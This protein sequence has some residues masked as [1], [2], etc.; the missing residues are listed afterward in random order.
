[1]K[2]LLVFPPQWTPFR[3]Y[4]SLPSL[5]A[6]L[7]EKGITVVQKDFNLEAYDLMLTRPYLSKIS[8]R[9]NTQFAA[10]ELK[11][12]LMPGIEQK[13][14]SDLFMAKSI[15]P[16]L[17]DKV[18]SAKS[19]YRDKDNFFDPDKL[20]SATNIINQALVAI[21]LA[22]FPTIIGLSTFEMSS[23]IG[24][25]ESLKAATQNRIENPY[26]EIFEEHLLPFIKNEQPD[27]IGITISGESQVIPAFTLCSVLR[28]KGIRGHI[29]V[30]GYVI[31]MLADVIPKYPELFERFIDSAIINDG[32]KPL[33]EL[34]KH[35]EQ[36]RSLDTVP[37]LIFRD[38]N[39]IRVNSKEAPE[40]I[41]SLP[42]PSFEGLPLD[43][44]FSPSPVLPL[45][46][47]RGCYWA[48][49][50]FCTHS[51]AY[52]LTYQLRDHVKVVDDIEA[53]SAKY[54]TTHIAFSDEGTS[55]ASVGKIS[56]EILRRGIKI[57]LST[58][59]RPE[60][61][62]TKELAQKMSAAGFKEVY[63]GVES[64]CD[65]VLKQINKGTE[66][67]S[68]EEYCAISMTPAFGITFT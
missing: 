28:Q 52:G 20:E 36:G 11:D 56:D 53:L 50:A 51:L 44:Y 21:S 42:A 32:E 9:L 63:I 26:I 8:E 41:N 57:R 17:A 43:K 25:Y 18:E 2:V 1:M 27:V 47:S 49:C 23:F 24:S 35:L 61:Q 66:I 6:Y 33:T 40:Y 39:K 34:I 54:G 60:R 68:N 46:S 10:L 58:S 5:T 31:S 29:A 12:Q 4:L 15:V 55:P 37:N 30:G 48:K 7:Q 16:D 38:G 19:V 62:F 3:P 14:Y 45:L 13:F 64:S 22:H 67:E 65:R 59:I